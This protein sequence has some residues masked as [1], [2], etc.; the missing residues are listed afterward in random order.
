MK[1]EKAKSLE[2]TQQTPEQVYPFV[3]ACPNEKVENKKVCDVCGH[4]NSEDSALC[5]MCSNYLFE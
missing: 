1:N 5:E 4:P 2:K 3:L